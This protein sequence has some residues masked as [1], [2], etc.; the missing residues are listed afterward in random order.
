[1]L[2][3][4]ST[5]VLGHTYSSMTTSTPRSSEEVDVADLQGPQQHD[6]MVLKVE[7]EEVE[8]PQENP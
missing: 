7:E 5:S 8:A 6:G 3:S 4:G 2:R 1:M